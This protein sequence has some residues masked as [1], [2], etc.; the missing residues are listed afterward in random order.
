MPRRAR[1]PGILAA[2][3]SMPDAEL[4]GERVATTADLLRVSD[5]ARRL[6]RH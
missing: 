5:V 3:R 6:E 1:F 2:S 4:S